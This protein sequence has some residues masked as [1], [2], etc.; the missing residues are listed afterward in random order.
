MVQGQT[1]E[2]TY[3]SSDGISKA[4]L[5]K[6]TVEKLRKAY[7]NGT[8][9]E[10]NFRYGGSTI[11]DAVQA[12]QLY[13]T[14][15]NTVVFTSHKIGMPPTSAL[16]SFSLQNRTPFGPLNT[17]LHN[18][19]VAADTGPNKPPVKEEKQIL[20]PRKSTSRVS[21]SAA[22]ISSSPSFGSVRETQPN[23][24]SQVRVKNENA[25]ASLSSAGFARYIMVPLLIYSFLR[26]FQSTN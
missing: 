16:S 21:S 7:H 12:R 2:S 26:I 4:G 25:E 3:S 20:S 6:Y 23:R 14:R 5:R 11:F 22:P 18:V 10:V 15:D 1:S 17:Q 9:P 13:S 19:P 24:L 8:E